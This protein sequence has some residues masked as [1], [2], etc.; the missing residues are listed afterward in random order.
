MAE[1]TQ[2]LLFHHDQQGIEDLNLLIAVRHAVSNNSMDGRG[3]IHCIHSVEFLVNYLEGATGIALQGFVDLD[4]H[5]C[6]FG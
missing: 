3:Q 5:S 4:L 2:S 1:L 6:G